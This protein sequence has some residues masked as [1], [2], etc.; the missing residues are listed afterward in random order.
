MRTRAFCCIPKRSNN[1]AS[2]SAFE[3]RVTHKGVYCETNLSTVQYATHPYPWFSCAHGDAGRSE[4]CGR[5][6]PPRPQTPDRVRRHVRKV[7]GDCVAVRRSLPRSA[8]ITEKADYARILSRGEKSRD[9]FF[10]CHVLLADTSE[11]RLGLVV[12]RKVGKAVVRNRIKRHIREFFRLNR[13]R[14][15]PGLQV[16]V[17][18]GVSSATLDG[19]ACARALEC[20]LQRWLRHA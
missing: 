6:T 9:R 19:P 3:L 14:L 10:V 15:A 5:A 18:A 12:S 2:M 20:L 7:A 16:V 8:R 4:D 17:V 1:A 11:T 13:A